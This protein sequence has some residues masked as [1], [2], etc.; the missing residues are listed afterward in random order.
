MAK[1]RSS[2]P[3][4]TVPISTRAAV[5]DEPEPPDTPETDDTPTQEAAEPPRREPPK[6][7]S[8]FQTMGRVQ[9]EDW[10]PR[11]SIYLYRLEPMIDRL[12]GGDK[13]YIMMYTEPLTEERI[14]VDH[15]SGRYKAVLNIRKAGAERGDEIDSHFF[16][17]MNLKYPPKVPKGEWVDDPRNKKWAW[18]KEPDVPPAPPASG[19]AEFTGVFRA[20]SELRKE[21]R[22]EMKP[23]Q[24]AQ[25]AQATS[26]DPW[27]AAERILN[28]RSDNPMIAILMTRMD[29]MDKAA[30]ASRLREADL[31]KELRE[32]M[33]VQPQAQPTVAPKT[34]MEQATELAEAAGKLKSI[35]GAASETGAAGTIVRAARMG[36]LEFLS[37]V[38]P[39]IAD[40]Q[41][42][43]AI[44]VRMLTSTPPPTDGIAGPPAQPQPQPVA[45]PNPQVDFENFMRFAITPALVQAMA[46][47]DTG[48]RFAEW[49]WDYYPNRLEQLQKFTHPR[50]PGL[51]GPAAIIMAYKASSVWP[52]LAMN[53]E[54]AFALFVQEFCAWKPEGEESPPEGTA[55]PSAGP[56]PFSE[57]TDEDQET[58]ERV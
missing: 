31:Q 19:L 35:F 45:H 37:E 39:K 42:L 10:G 15:G 40:S 5:L 25:P 55:P 21:I 7:P 51:M 41:I 6:V 11:A 2:K 47:K 52:T 27:A 54:E 18:A 58:Q 23:E 32:Q 12:R 13:K 9:K 44:A 48:A 50:L 26:V 22:E 30:E 1:S 24:P 17:I 8:F 53:G 33:R 43:N 4:K 38:I 36:T 20:A 14:M 29:T 16:D 49:V 34:L 46:D 56:T 57:P 3:E 28:M